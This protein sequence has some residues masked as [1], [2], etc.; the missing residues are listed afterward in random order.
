MK[1]D[2]KATRRRI[3]KRRKVLNMTQDDVAEATGKAITI[4]QI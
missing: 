4:S 3:A 1:I 2:Y